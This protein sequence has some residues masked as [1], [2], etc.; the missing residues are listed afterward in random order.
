MQPNDIQPKEMT[1]ICCP[2][3]C[4]LQIEKIAGSKDND[5]YNISGN[6]C[7]RGKAYAIEEM[8]APKRVVTSTVAIIGSTHP[9]IP[10]KTSTPIPKEKIF[11][12]MQILSNLKVTSPV[13]AGDVLIANIANT[14]ANLIATKDSLSL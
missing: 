8:T 4:T 14:D 10:V 12:V 2:L 5:G 6:K 1:C 3:G 7:P 9:V 11:E 13:K